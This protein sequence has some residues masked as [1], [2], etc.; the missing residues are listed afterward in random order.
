LEFSI[1]PLNREKYILTLIESEHS[2]SRDTFLVS[3]NYSQQLD[4]IIGDTTSDLI[5]NNPINWSKTLLGGCN[6]M[7]KSA[8][9]DNELESDTL[10]F[11]EL[12]DTL[13]IFVGINSTC[14]I[15]FGSESS[16]TGDTLIMRI[17]TLNDDQCDCICYY[18]FDYYY[19]NYSGQ[20]FYYQFFVDEYKQFE[21]IYNLP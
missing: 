1:G 15:D 2:Y 4:T 10:I 12:N 7:Y 16:I 9:I 18:T 21:G 20:G 3:F 13:R 17:I 8:T 14:C 5:S 11:Y 6:N 19:L